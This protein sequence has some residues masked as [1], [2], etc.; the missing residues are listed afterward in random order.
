[1]SEKLK[2]ELGL[3]D[4]FSISAGAMISSGLFILPALAYAKTGPSMILAYLLASV[5]IIP[6]MLSKAELAT[7]MPKSGGTFFYIDRSLGPRMGTIGGLAAWFS[8]ALKSAFALVGI[9][10]FTL[11]LNPG[12]SEI[13]IKLIAVAFCIIFTVINIIGVKHTGKTQ[14][15]L[16]AG[17][18]SLLVIYIIW[19]SFSIQSSRYSVSKLPGFGPIFATAGLVFVSFG[20]LTKICSVAEETKNPGR[21]IPLGMAIAWGVVSLLYG[22]VI[23]VTVGL[24]NVDDIQ[25][26][27]TPISHGG[28]I[29]AGQFGLVIMSIAAILAFISTANGGLLAASRDPM[30]M[31]KDELLPGFFGKVSKRGTPVYSILFTSAFMICVILFLDMESLVK[32]A[33]TLKI[34]LFL[35][36]MVSLIVIR[37]S[38]IKHYHPKFRSPLFPWIQIFGIIV[39]VFL[40]FKM[41]TVPLL[42]V[43]FFIVF[44][45]CWYFIYSSGKIKRE[46]ALL[47]IVERVTGIKTTNYLLDEELR[48]IVIERD[49]ITEKR[50]EDLIKKCPVIDFKTSLSQDKFSKIVANSLAKRLRIKPSKIM[51][52]LIKREED[53]D[54]IIHS[55]LAIPF[56]KIP[57][58]SKFEIMLVRDIEGIF[59]SEEDSPIYAAFII[60]ATP[61]ERNFYLHALMWLVQ[62]AE[63]IDFDKE[64]L[65]AKNIEELHNV[66]LSSWRKRDVEQSSHNGR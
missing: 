12:F 13:E 35:L 23:I 54:T 17:L 51:K 44:G 9:G 57:G 39:Y 7:A 29:F 49:D 58:H 31:G 33:S 3:L 15:V 47:H 36:V 46:Y 55:G 53:P 21:D 48:E 27:L 45:G 37:R 32:T 66:I 63:G 40:I 8:L 64:W 25:G 30:A 65:G 11:L 60:V 52:L 59:I 50:F 28:E 42:I 5:L 2:K 56:I 22:L 19:G 4:L 1:M 34:L 61:D 38:K 41:G 24:L 43:G 10:V 18:L 62:I 16:V 26:S 6:A 14:R 20:G